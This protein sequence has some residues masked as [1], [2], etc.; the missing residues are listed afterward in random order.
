MSEWKMVPVEPTPEM[1]DAAETALEGSID[2]IHV[3]D[4]HFYDGA[5]HLDAPP[6]EHSFA[7][8]HVVH[9]R[10]SG[11]LRIWHA[12]LAAAPAAPPVAAPGRET[13]PPEVRLNDDGTLDEIVG[14]GLFH[15]EQ[16]H[17]NHWWMC[18]ESAGKR[19]DVNIWTKKAHI[20]ANVEHSEST[21]TSA[22]PAEAREAFEQWMA[23]PPA[24][25]TKEEW[26]GESQAAEAREAQGAEPAAYYAKPR[27]GSNRVPHFV[28]SLSDLSDELRECFDLTPLYLAPPVAQEADEQEAFDAWWRRPDRHIVINRTDAWCGWDARA[29]LSAA[30]V[31]SQ[32]LPT[33]DE[34]NWKHPKLQALLANEAR[35]GIR[36]A[37]IKDLIA[38]PDCETTAM[39][40]EYWD[41][42]H[43]K[44]KAALKAV[45]STS[46][47]RAEAL[48]E[49]ARICESVNNSD[50]P[51]TAKDCADAILAL[52][53]QP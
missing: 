35:L 42:T 31:A 6:P 38:D 45:S 26:Q 27:A 16:M 46:Q 9:G 7:D 41:S 32:A 22:P 17:N 11:P 39:D 43:D 50:N 29:S 30:P 8:A 23:R 14:S 52:K 24:G 47:V 34:P 33:A 4:R 36:L 12:M 3:D 49:A 44:L 37:L 10:R 21:Y 18:F 53:D 13:K 51:M 19:V 40:M 25:L 28:I 1:L 15:L 5:W 2:S 48:E 20:T